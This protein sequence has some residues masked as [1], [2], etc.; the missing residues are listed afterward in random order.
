M[1]DDKLQLY[2]L[3]VRYIKAGR[4]AY[5]GHLEVLNTINRSIRRSELPFSVGNGFA[6]RIRLQFSQALPVGASSLA[7]YY[8]LM[9][10]EP[11]DEERALAALRA[12]TPRGLEPQVV[13]YLPRKVPALE[14]WAN[15]SAWHIELFGTGLTARGVD[16]A[17][18]LLLKRGTLEYLRGTKPKKLE[19]GSTLVGWKLEPAPRGLCMELDTRSTNDG[20]LRPA[21][22]LGAALHE[23]PL[24]EARLDTLRVER[25]GQWHESQDGGLVD[26]LDF[27]GTP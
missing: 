3:R 18:D 10:T 24:A 19:L 22:L 26:P 2:R 14:A 12:A 15:R 20:A 9:L 4:L 25:R 23:G 11:V 13:R 1:T 27:P 16:D 5:L 8:D 17:I 21:V 7:E 6:H